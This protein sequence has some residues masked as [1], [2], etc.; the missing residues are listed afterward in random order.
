VLNRK[1]L[2][3]DLRQAMKTGDDVRKRTL[4]ML[5]SAIKLAE[6]E[7]RGPLDEQ[8]MLGLLQKEVKFRH[9]SIRDAERAHRD[10]LIAASQAELA[11]LHSFLPEA[12]SQ[13]ALH[14]VVRQTIEE[15]GASGP[16][17]MGKVMK[18]VLPRIQGRANGKDVSELVRSLLAQA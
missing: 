7:Q 2:E 11:F 9:E 8:S 10:D 5:L 13:E 1:S 4:R 16:H 6:V 3:E 15:I 12:L 14:A 17:D 18:A